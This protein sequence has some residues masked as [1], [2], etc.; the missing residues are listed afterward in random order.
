MLRPYK[1]AHRDLETRIRLELFAGRPCLVSYPADEFP[2][3]HYS[4]I[5][6]SIFSKS[7]IRWHNFQTNRETLSGTL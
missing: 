3:S 5:K 7:G 2:D 6:P 1:E 4:F